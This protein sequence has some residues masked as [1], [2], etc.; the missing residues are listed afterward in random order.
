VGLLTITADLIASWIDKPQAVNWIMLL[1]LTVFNMSCSSIFIYWF[2]RGKNF[3]AMNL[4]RILNSFS[5]VALSLLLAFTDFK[6]QGLILGYVIGNLLTVSYVWFNYLY[7]EVPL[8]REKLVT[9]C[10]KYS[11]YPKFLIPATL[12]GTVSSESIVLLLTRLFDSYVAGLFYFVNRVTLSPMSIIGN[13]I[14]EVYR[15]KATEHYQKKGECL[16]EFKRNLALLAAIGFIPWVALFFFGPQ[17]FMIVFGEQWRPAGE[18]AVTMSFVVWF[19]LVSTPLSYTIVLNQSQNLDLYLQIFRLLGS[20]FSI[21]FGFY[22]ESYHVGIMLV[23]VT[24]CSYYLGHTLIQYR[25]AKG[26]V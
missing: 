26:I 17:L 24:Y 13:S 10:S 6:S 23:A 5:I 12:A 16:D 4:F 15:I 8:N 20:I 18:I 2:N 21:I 9:V 19:Q 22:W 14:G 3:Q 1:P 7:K 25:A 11:R